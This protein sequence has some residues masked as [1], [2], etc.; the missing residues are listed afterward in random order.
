[1]DYINRCLFCMETMPNDTSECPH[2][3]RR[4][5]PKVRYSDALIPGTILA[6]R[7]LIGEVTERSD[8]LIRY[9][10][11]DCADNEKVFVDEFFPRSMASREPGELK[12]EIDPNSMMLAERAKKAWLNTDAKTAFQENMTV[13]IVYSEVRKRTPDEERTVMQISLPE[14]AVRKKSPRKAIGAVL[15]C[16]GL[17]L[18]AFG[19]KNYFTFQTRSETDEEVQTIVVPEQTPEAVSDDADSV[20]ADEKTDENSKEEAA[21]ENDGE[22]I[23]DAEEAAPELQTPDTADM[24]QNEGGADEDEDN[25]LKAVPEAAADSG[26]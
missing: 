23:P 21:D 6:A 26:Q 22:Q 3:G 9:M 17:V 19:A 13:Y 1:M 5:V 8:Y 11:F 20:E 4:G 10:A 14:K 18:T 2:C 25:A 7:Y 12:I 15:V 16:M 24:L